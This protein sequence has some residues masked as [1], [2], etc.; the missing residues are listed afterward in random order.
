MGRKRVPLHKKVAGFAIERP[1]IHL[2]A[3]ELN[4]WRRVVALEEPKARMGGQLRRWKRP[5]L[6]QFR[7]SA[8]GEKPTI[9]VPTDA[10]HRRPRSLPETGNFTPA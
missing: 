10:H 6:S 4:T 5:H 9:N 7:M 1:I 8:N 3:L 2:V